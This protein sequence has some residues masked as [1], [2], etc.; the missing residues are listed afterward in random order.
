MKRILFTGVGRRIELLQAFKRAAIMLDTDIRIYGA[1]MAGTA[2][3]LCYCDETRH[4]CAMK[5]PDYI[6]ELLQICS[7]DDI[8]LLIPTIDTDLVVLSENKDKFEKIG[9][10]VLI[11]SP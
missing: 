9:T 1:D 3:A 11:S 4:I 2:P 10:S 5:D 7:N 8:D 6:S